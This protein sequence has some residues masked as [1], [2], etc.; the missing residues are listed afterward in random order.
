LPDPTLLRMLLQ[1]L[2]MI[3]EVGEWPDPVCLSFMVLIPKGDPLQP[4]GGDPLQLRPIT[5]LS[6]VYR[7]W[8]KLRFDD[9]LRWVQAWSPQTVNAS[10]TGT[11]P[12]YGG[13]LLDLEAASYDDH[14]L[15]VATWD[16]RKCFDLVQWDIL[17]EVLK[18]RG[19]PESM[20]TLMKHMYYKLQRRIKL[21]GRQV[22]PAWH[23]TNGLIQGDTLSIVGLQAIVTIWLEAGR[24]CLPRDLRLRA[25]VDDKSAT[26]RTIAGVARVVQ[27]TEDFARLAHMQLARDKCY[28]TARTAEG[29]AQLR[30]KGPQGYPVVECL[31]L[32]GIDIATDE[33]RTSGTMPKKVAKAV[34]KTL[35]R[36]Q[37]IAKSGLWQA[38]K[39]RCMGMS[40]T[41]CLPH[42]TA[43]AGLPKAQ[44]VSIRDK[45]LT[46]QG[47]SH[48][49][50]CA[51]IAMVT[52]YRTHLDPFQALDYTALR[53]VFRL[54]DLLE[55]DAD[56]LERWLD[57]AKCTPSGVGPLRRGVDILRSIGW[58]WTTLN[59]WTDDT[60]YQWDLWLEEPGVLWHAVRSALRQR[61][62]KKVFKPNGQPRREYMDGLEQGLDIPVTTQLLRANTLPAYE[63]GILRHLIACAVVTEKDAAKWKAVTPACKCCGHAS[64]D[65]QHIFQDCEAHQQA[66]QPLIQAME[67][68]GK[69][70]TDFP[71]CLRFYGL[72]P[73]NVEVWLQELT[74]VL[75]RAYV[76]ILLGRTE[77]MARGDTDDTDD[78]PGGPS[79]Q[80]PHDWHRT[81]LPRIERYQHLWDAY[82]EQSR[83][84][85]SEQVPEP[86]G[87]HCRGCEAWGLAL[88]TLRRRPCQDQS[89][90]YRQGKARGAAIRHLER[91]QQPVVGHSFMWSGLIN[92]PV[93]CV[94]CGFSIAFSTYKAAASE[95]VLADG[96][97]R[98]HAFPSCQ[99]TRE[100][101]AVSMDDTRQR[102]RAAYVRRHPAP[103]WLIDPAG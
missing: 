15:Y 44:M 46:V 40:A 74:P 68:F 70:W 28:L 73:L 30:Q 16:Y 76:Q 89:E 48:R 33:V 78:T 35:T 63:G 102:R 71:L 96:R 87:Y 6:L 99:P 60:G 97:L 91:M 103:D 27:L 12:V 84:Q 4:Y 2:S 3:E 51:E 10:F 90:V 13:V 61:E 29:L 95:Q 80:H 34:K 79:G 9:T 36:I 17:F 83:L 22:G 93:Q 59:T 81:S 88:Y 24:A 92:D 54:L 98:S 50:R 42:A 58:E 7:L 14:E 1:L 19:M 69:G 5:V 65:L 62:V 100:V 25:Y 52:L 75:Q 94:E 41:S 45:I 56:D 67:R 64:E 37:R 11:E 101:F 86:Q 26:C 8:S 85:Q 43:M 82:D 47:F 72:C 49:K 53:I 32:L 55:H 57:R 39:A 21:A 38:A 66:R 77:A 23:M 18:R 31:A 20:I